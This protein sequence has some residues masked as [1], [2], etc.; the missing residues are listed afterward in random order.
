MISSVRASARSSVRP[1][2]RPCTRV[3]RDVPT[4]V[5]IIII[6]I[7]VSTSSIISQR[8]EW[9]L[10]RPPAPNGRSR[11]LCTHMYGRTRESRTHKK[12][13]TD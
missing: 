5:I 10:S 13:V 2:V 1:S 9:W 4:A 12:K 7:I 6:F 3:A 8:N 11:A